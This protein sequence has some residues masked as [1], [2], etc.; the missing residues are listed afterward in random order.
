MIVILDILG[1]EIDRRTLPANCLLGVPFKTNSTRL[2]LADH[3]CRQ[4]GGR[5]RCQCRFSDA[6]VARAW[7]TKVAWNPHAA[8]TLFSMIKFLFLVV[9]LELALHS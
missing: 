1:A 3:V 2:A 6:Q 4:L 8:Q 9:Y 5:Q 7:P